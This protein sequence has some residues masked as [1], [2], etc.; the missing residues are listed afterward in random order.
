M[1]TDIDGQQTFLDLRIIRNSNIYRKPTH[2]ECCLK[3]HGY[4]LKSHQHAIFSRLVN[5]LLSTPLQQIEYTRT[6][7]SGTVL[8]I[9]GVNLIVI[10]MERP[11]LVPTVIMSLFLLG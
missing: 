10:Y 6:I 8:N 3:S 1:K 5:I 7:G 2:T 9:E 4:N 11:P